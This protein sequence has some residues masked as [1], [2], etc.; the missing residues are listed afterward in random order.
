M[1]FGLSGEEIMKSSKTLRLTALPLQVYPKIWTDSTFKL[2]HSCGIITVYFFRLKAGKLGLGGGGGEQSFASVGNSGLGKAK[3]KL[4]FNFRFGPKQVLNT[5]Q[6]WTAP[7][8][9]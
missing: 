7:H 9:T 6:F 3:L 1:N 4:R 8:I 2:M 5:M